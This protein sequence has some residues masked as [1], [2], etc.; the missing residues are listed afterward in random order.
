M[1]NEQTTPGND[2]DS[3]LTQLLGFNARQTTRATP[4]A[5]KEA[6]D[7]IKLEKTKEA[8]AVAKVKIQEVMKLVQEFDKVEKDFMKSKQKFDKSARK[9]INEL[10]AMANGTPIPEP[11][12]ADAA[13]E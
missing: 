1:A 6:L 11:E 5:F 3:K 7:E 12:P 10:S 4:D 13:K 8:K 9:Y 2:V